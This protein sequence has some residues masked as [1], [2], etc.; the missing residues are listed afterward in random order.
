MGRNRKPRKAYRRGRVDLD[1]VDM[2]KARVS[3][4]TIAQRL[5]LMRPLRA[6]FTGLRT[7]T[8]HWPAWCGM[9][10]G[11]NVAEQLALS[12]IARDRLP[13]FTA[14]Q[15]AMHALHS[16]VVAGGSWTMRAQE[17][18]ALE[19][20]VDLHGIQL[21]FASQGEVA[22]AS[23]AV[24]RNVQQAL[25][26]NAPRDAKVCVGVL[27]TPRPALLPTAPTPAESPTHV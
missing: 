27:G 26:G 1:P 9:A 18:T 2:T 14:G 21:Q 17:I 7:A 6:A 13:E 25:K 4:L 22:N 10:Y 15:A 8:G 5:D 20:A 3:T 23:E 12:G 19:F 11:L 16:R 24:K